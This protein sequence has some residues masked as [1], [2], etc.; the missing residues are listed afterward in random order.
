MQ[1]TRRRTGA[2]RTRHAANG[3]ALAE[4]A[5]AAVPLLLLLLGI[6]QFALIYNAQVGL[7]NGVRD[8]ARYGSSL[9]AN[10]DAA[11]GQAADLTI[12]FLG[13]ALAANVVPYDAAN[14][15]V[16]TQ[17]CFA[18][19]TDTPL[20]T[21]IRVRVTAV[22][23]HPLVVPL[24]NLIVDAA[25]GNSDGLYTISSTIELRVDNPPDPPLAVAGAQCRS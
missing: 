14:V 16:G 22:Y 17:V 7:T 10:T 21:E 1:F 13:T 11:A 4:F 2:R 23:G 12:A 18:P 19:G 6:L 8:A 24:I 3:Q 15:G 9:V 5:V 20:P 25:D